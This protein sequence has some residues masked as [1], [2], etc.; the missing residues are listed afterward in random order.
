LA[1]PTSVLAANDQVLIRQ[2]A[3]RDEAIV[4]FDGAR[5]ATMATMIRL[6]TTTRRRAR[7]TVAGSRA[8]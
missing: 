5:A 2:M 6:T 7:P 8:A 4:A 1:K 3:I